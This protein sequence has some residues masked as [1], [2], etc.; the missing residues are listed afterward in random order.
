[1][2]TVAK[3]DV[4]SDS[5]VML[6]K[7]TTIEFPLETPGISVDIRS[8]ISL[9]AFPHQASFVFTLSVVN[10]K[11]ITEIGSFNIGGAIAVRHRVIS[12]DVFQTSG[13]TL[14]IEG[15]AGFGEISDI[16]LWYQ[17]KV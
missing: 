9:M 17:G 5:A 13:N 10:S 14:K 8:L 2:P 7:G 4:V 1:M 3:Y 16:M 12:T 11:A 6:K 15:K